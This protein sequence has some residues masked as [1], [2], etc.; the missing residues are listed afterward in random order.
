MSNGGYDI[1]HQNIYV[2]MDTHSLGYIQGGGLWCRQVNSV[3]TLLTQKHKSQA[4]HLVTL[5]AVTKA[6]TPYYTY[7]LSSNQSKLSLFQAH[8]SKDIPTNRLLT[9]K[10]TCR[11]NKTT[12]KQA[13]T[14]GAQAWV[15]K[16]IISPMKST[17]KV[18]I[19]K[20]M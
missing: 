11:G 6:S 16:E 12:N 13:N 5:K 18:W 19:P 3:C 15:L 7:E 20:G 1:P 4:L 2:T 14:R 8:Q 17:N 9:Y 10:F